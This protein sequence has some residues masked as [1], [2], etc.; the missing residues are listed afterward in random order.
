MELKDLKN[1]TLLDLRLTKVT[2][3][4]LKELQEALPKCEIDR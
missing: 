3:V 4:G 2:D 1:L